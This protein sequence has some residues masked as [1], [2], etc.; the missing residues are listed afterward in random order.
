MGKV[1]SSSHSSGF[2]ST[3]ALCSYTRNTHTGKG[4]SWHNAGSFR[5]GR[6]RMRVHASDSFVVRASWSGRGWSAYVDRR[7][8]FEETKLDLDARKNEIFF[9]VPLRDILVVENIRDIPML[10]V[11][12]PDMRTLERLI[13]HPKVITILEEGIY[14]PARL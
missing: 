1:D 6:I 4:G 12:V 5:G 2:T 10:K 7:Q 11:R 14:K 9:N 3:G 13:S 8:L